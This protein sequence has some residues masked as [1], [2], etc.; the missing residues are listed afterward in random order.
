MATVR[1]ETGTQ[2]STFVAAVFAFIGNFRIL[3]EE[4]TIN[5]EQS[6]G[7]GKSYHL[8]LYLVF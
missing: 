1:L 5:S 3:Y 4:F 2:C 6:N 7:N 8:E